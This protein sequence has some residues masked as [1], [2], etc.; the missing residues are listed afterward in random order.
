MEAYSSL[1]L[2]SLA[3]TDA[4]YRKPT[5]LS[6]TY[7]LLFHLKAFVFSVNTSNVNANVFQRHDH[8]THSAK[9]TINV[10]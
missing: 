3:R 10:H 2:G 1:S 7:P 4:L 6:S 8:S 9:T 5:I